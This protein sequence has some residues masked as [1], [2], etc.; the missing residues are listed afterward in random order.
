MND[1]SG[2]N[3]LRQS[4]ILDKRP[5]SLVAY[6]KEKS[7]FAEQ[8]RKIRTN[9]EFSKA[10]GG[11]KAIMVTSSGSNEGK[12]TTAAN[13]AVVMAQ[14]GRKVLLID[15]DMRTPSMHYTFHLP[16]RDGLTTLLTKNS[17]FEDIAQQS[18]IGNLSILTSGPVPP[19]PAD[20]LSSSEMAGFVNR[21]R[22]LFDVIIIDSPPILDVADAQVLANLCDG[23][24]LVVRSGSTEVDDA[25]KAAECLSEA[26]AR[27]LGV[28]LNDLK[29]TKKERKGRSYRAG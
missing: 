16:N 11:L 28:V 5:R 9:I 1:S 12:S 13:L 15:A 22:N 8:Y 29:V 24:L 17:R 19:N 23:I 6:Y 10:G 18:G 4:K 27:I 20:L 3:T 26:K 21:F 14:Q 2:V 25:R 7:S